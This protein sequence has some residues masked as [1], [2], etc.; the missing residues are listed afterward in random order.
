[1]EVV[2]LEEL[3]VP[4]ANTS[5]VVGVNTLLGL[6]STAIVVVEGRDKLGV[7]LEETVVSDE[8]IDELLD[9]L[10]MLLVVLS[11]IELTILEAGS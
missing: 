1:M 8:L 3:T 2:S 9:M 6:E 10:V 11:I 4:E 5:V 7:A